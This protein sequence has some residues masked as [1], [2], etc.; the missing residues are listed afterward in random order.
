[1]AEGRFLGGFTRFGYK[2]VD[3]RLVKNLVEQR[4]IKEMKDMRRRGMSL[5][6]I[7]GWLNQTHN[8]KMSHSTVAILVA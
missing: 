7:S 8:L 6:R 2:L 1:M 4:I 5:R 3:E